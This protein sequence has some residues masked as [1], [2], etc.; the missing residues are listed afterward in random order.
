MLLTMT[1]LAGRVVTRE[2]A[3]SQ[4]GIR[5]YSG[6]DLV[7]TIET[8]KKQ[9]KPFVNGMMEWYGSMLFGKK[10][11]KTS[12]GEEPLDVSFDGGHD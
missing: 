12:R 2:K 4:S 9:E 7:H 10:T 11:M 3:R 5:K 1:S 8:A 6:D